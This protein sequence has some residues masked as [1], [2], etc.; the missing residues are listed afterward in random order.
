ML[1]KNDTPWYPT[2]Q[3]FRQSKIGDWVSLINQIRDELLVFF[4]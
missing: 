3:L 2:A 4:A 1:D